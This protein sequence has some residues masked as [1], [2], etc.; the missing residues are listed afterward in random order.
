MSTPPL[1]PSAADIGEP[2]H[3]CT[4]LRQS[5][6]RLDAMLETIGDAFFAVDRQWRITYANRKAATFVGWI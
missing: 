2:H 4:L 1:S 5:R 6:A 3:A